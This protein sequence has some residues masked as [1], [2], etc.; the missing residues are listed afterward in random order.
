VYLL[1]I[2]PGFGVSIFPNE[3]VVEVES[4]TVVGC[5]ANSVELKP[6]NRTTKKSILKYDL[7][8]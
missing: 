5:W 1:S 3:K 6:K 4:L 2:L 7:P 8:L